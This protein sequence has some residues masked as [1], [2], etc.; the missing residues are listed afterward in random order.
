VNGAGADDDEKTA[1]GKTE[2]FENLL[3]GVIDKAGRGVA[4]GPLRFEGERRVDH[5]G[6][7]DAEVVNE[8]LHGDDGAGHNELF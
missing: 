6:G 5:I 7:A 8:M 4:D 1:V 3:T 2:D